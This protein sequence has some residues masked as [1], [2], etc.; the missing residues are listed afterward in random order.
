MRRILPTTF[1]ALLLALATPTTGLA[2][3]DGC[4]ADWSAAAPIVKEEGLV[5]VEELSRAASSRLSGDIVRATLCREKGVYVFRLVVKGV[6]GHL[7]AVTVDA[8]RPF[9]R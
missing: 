4:V 6:S 3:A 5:T 2:G 8:R 7:R 1:A 9:D